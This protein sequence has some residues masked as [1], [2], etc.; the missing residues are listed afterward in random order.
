MK[1]EVNGG[2]IGFNI[3]GQGGDADSE[4]QGTGSISIIG[5]LSSR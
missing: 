5:S 3:T 2:A 1:V 4:A